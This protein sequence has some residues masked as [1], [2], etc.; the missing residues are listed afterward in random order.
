MQDTT[1][2]LEQ[3]AVP[4]PER[5]AVL[6]FLTGV[7]VDRVERTEHTRAEHPGR[8]RPWSSRRAKPPSR[9]RGMQ[10]FVHMA[11]RRVR[12]CTA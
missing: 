6:A 11:G 4:P 3:C 7:H 8:E 2:M 9:R 1:A 10:E 5:D 12:V